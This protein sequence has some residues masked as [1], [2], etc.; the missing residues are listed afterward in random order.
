MHVSTSRRSSRD[1]LLAC[2]I[3]AACAVTGS[4]LSALEGDQ[5]PAPKKEP[6]RQ[7]FPIVKPAAAPAGLIAAVPDLQQRRRRGIADILERNAYFRSIFFRNATIVDA[8]LAGPFEYTIKKMFSDETKTRTLYCA[9]GSVKNIIVNALIE[10]RHPAEGGEQI[11]GTV[12]RS[13]NFF[14]CRKAD[15]QP[16]PELEQLRVQRLRAAGLLQ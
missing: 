15:Y 9:S 3:L 12:S 10:V 16:F 13:D 7:T 8:K 14:E 4:S 1:R 2:L 5:K 6:A 11:S